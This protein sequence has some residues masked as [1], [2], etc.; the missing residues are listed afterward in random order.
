MLT[1]DTTN[2]I[3]NLRTTWV[4]V[5]VVVVVVAI[6]VNLIK[7]SL[8]PANSSASSMLKTLVGDVDSPLRRPVSG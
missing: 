2:V 8:P 4:F 5:V 6:V 1:H 7:S 3:R